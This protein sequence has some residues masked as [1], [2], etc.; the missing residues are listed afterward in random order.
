MSELGESIQTEEA[1]T[2]RNRKYT[3]KGLE[4]QVDQTKRHLRSCIVSWR[5]VAN[6]I[7]VLLSDCT[8]VETIRTERYHLED[9][10][11]DVRSLYG[12]LQDLINVDTHTPEI[13]QQVDT[14]EGENTRIMI[15]ISNHILELERENSTQNSQGSIKSR[16][17]S[18][19]KSE[20]SN[21]SRRSNISKRSDVAI[22]AATLISKLKYM[23]IEA[24][25][26]VE[27]E[28]IETMK[29]LEVAR[30][31]LEILKEDQYHQ[32]SNTKPSFTTLPADGMKELLNKYVESC[33]ASVAEHFEHENPSPSFIAARPVTILHCEPAGI[34]CSDSVVPLTS[35]CPN[36][37]VQ[38][39]AIPVVKPKVCISLLNPS[40]AAFVSVSSDI[41]SSKVPSVLQIPQYTTDEYPIGPTLPASSIPCV[42]PIHN[43]P[44]AAPIHNQP[45]LLPFI[46]SLRL[47][48]FITSLLRLPFTISLRLLP[49]TIS[50]RLLLFIASLRLLPFITS[51]RLLP[52]TTRFR[53]IALTS[54]RLFHERPITIA[55]RQ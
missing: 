34:P 23:D 29:K 32:T 49:F 42:A 54:L 16:Q 37:M 7:S 53:L 24:K 14:I 51:F 43:Q 19:R 30:V 48:P 25:S 3:D 9:I 45:S 50:L 38:T 12:K 40:S 18:S 46:T 1:P 28:K 2:T 8:D 35:S 27:L 41:A 26:R 17:S 44:L 36:P 52:F 55:Q 33:H 47:L 10:M 11:F 22:E 4:W 5:S 39:G 6:K 20:H 21:A 15:N 31:K 13:V